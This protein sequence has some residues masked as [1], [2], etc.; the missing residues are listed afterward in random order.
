VPQTA[1]VVPQTAGALQAAA[2]LDYAFAL[3]DAWY[4]QWVSPASSPSLHQYLEQHGLVV[5]HP[6][7]PSELTALGDVVLGTMG[8]RLQVIGPPKSW[9]SVAAGKTFT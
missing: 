9:V 1:S 4:G 6:Q 8:V 3:S 2:E 5:R 7:Q